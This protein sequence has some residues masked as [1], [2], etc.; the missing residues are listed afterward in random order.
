VPGTQFESSQVHHAVTRYE[1][2]WLLPNGPELAGSAVR[3]PVSAETDD[4]YRALS[5]ELSLGLESRFPEPRSSRAETRFDWKFIARPAQ[6]SG[7]DETIRPAS[8]RGGPLPFREGVAH[9][10]L[11]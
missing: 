8:R 1:I 10:S 5:A 3:V 7:A 11:P 9:R 4:G 6:A 2:S